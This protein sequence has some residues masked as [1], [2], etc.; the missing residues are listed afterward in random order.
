M[1][2]PD[3]SPAT[4]FTKG[5][6]K[7]G[8]RQ[9]GT[10]NKPITVKLAMRTFTN[11][12]GAELMAFAERVLFELPDIMPAGEKGY[13]NLLPA[14]ISVFVESLRSRSSSRSCPSRTTPIGRARPN[15]G[16]HV[17]FGG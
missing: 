17:K 8:G 15:E 5:R 4:R 9:K 14:K 12:R 1:P 11:E 6:P 13:V 10:P 7:T 2:N 3:P 16:R